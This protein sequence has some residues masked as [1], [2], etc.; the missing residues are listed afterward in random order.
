MK[1][2]ELTLRFD[3]G[4]PSLTMDDIDNLLFEGG[5]DDALVSHNGTNLIML[6]FNRAAINKDQ[7]TEAAIRAVTRAL[8][9]ARLVG[10]L[11]CAN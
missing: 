10:M 2:F 9:M 1:Q 5:F 3:V 8:P 11:P 6:S 4:D 7:A